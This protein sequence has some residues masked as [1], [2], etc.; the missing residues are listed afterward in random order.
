MPLEALAGKLVVRTRQQLHDQHLQ[1]VLIRNPNADVRPGGQPDIDANVMADAA[2]SLL[3][4]AVIIANNTQAATADI[5]ALTNVWAPLRGTQAQGAA[6]AAGSVATITSSGGAVILEGDV[7]THLPTGMTFEVTAS[8]TYNSTTPIPIAGITTGPQTDLEA[9]T[10]LTWQNPRPGVTVGTATVLPQSDGS[11]LEGGAGPEGAS[12]LRSRL[13]YIAFNPPASGNSAEYEDDIAT[14]SGVAV[15]QGFVYPGVIGPGGVGLTFTLRPGQPGANRIPTSTQLALVIAAVA[16]SMPGSDGIYPCTLLANLVTVVLKITWAPNADSWVD[17][18]P[19]PLYHASPNLVSAA[20]NGGGTLS[21]VAFRL[22]SSAMTEI[23]QVGQSIAFFDLPDQTYRR[24]KFLTVTTIS[25]TI[26]DVTVDTTGGISDTGYTPAN[27]QPCCPWSDSLD[28]MLLP[29]LS[30]FDTLGPGEQYASFFDP[31]LRQKRD[32]ASP[33]YYPSSVTGRILGGSQV[34]QN[35]QGPQQNQPPVP[36]LFNTPT[37]S[38][39]LLIEPTIPYAAPIGTP[40]VSSY[41][42]VLGDL[43]AFPE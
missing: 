30:Y 14:V 39:V 38:D 25:S 37:I 10:V 12:D 19:F 41:L 23:P 40:G 9:G 21:P 31:G 22:Q 20:P 7:L 26:Y 8:G 18:S 5:T 35:P 2:T 24:K 11:G 43:L 4:N 36:T 32:P 29:V 13:S 17:L 3:S 27:G 16:G 15:Q 33:Q 6:G 34:P 1:F 42:N 28:S